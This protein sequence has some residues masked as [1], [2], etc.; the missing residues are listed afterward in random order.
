M[1]IKYSAKHQIKILR[2]K[3]RRLKTIAVYGRYLLSKQPVLFGNSMPKS[4]SHLLIQILHGFTSVG[5]FIDNGMPPVNRSEENLNLPEPEMVKNISS[6]QSG[7]ISYGYLQA[8]EPFL[9]L[10]TKPEFATLFIYRDP[11]D[12]IVSHVFY[13]TDMYPGHGM[14]EFYTESLASTEERINAAI[15]GV[16]QPGYELSSIR[17]K[18]EKYL[19][20]FE[21][22]EI[23][24]IPFESLILKRE[25][26][27]SDILD[28]VISKGYQ[29]AH[30]RDKIMEV[31]TQAIQPQKSGTF[32]KGKPGNWREYFTPKNIAIFKKET[33][34]LLQVLGYEKDQDWS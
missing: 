31:L 21:Q 29:P 24:P 9:S 27:L 4:G 23:F 13:A 26:S 22:P 12:V 17:T 18:Y 3:S 30:S 5:P 16:Q 20:W 32:R 25:E 2:W 11:R 14:N 7:D 19:G 6:L 34:D 1:S 15:R 10:L 28:F 8:R 33:G